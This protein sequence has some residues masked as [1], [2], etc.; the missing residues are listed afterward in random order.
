MSPLP[1]ESQFSCV[2]FILHWRAN[3]VPLVTTVNVIGLLPS[4]PVSTYTKKDF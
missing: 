3:P 1:I 2:T 4:N